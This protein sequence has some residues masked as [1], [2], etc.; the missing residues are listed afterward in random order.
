[1]PAAHIGGGA[2]GQRGRVGDATAAV[3]ATSGAMQRR[4]RTGQR[5]QAAVGDARRATTTL[6]PARGDGGEVLGGTGAGGEEHGHG[7]RGNGE[8]GHGRV[9]TM[10]SAASDAGHGH[11][12]HEPAGPAA[13]HATATAMSEGRAEHR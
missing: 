13:R 7:R 2:G 10:S 1:M 9:A 3:P 6:V 11:R 5:G 12:E 4:S 8:L